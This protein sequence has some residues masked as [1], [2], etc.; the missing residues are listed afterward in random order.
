MIK[1][2]TKTDCGICVLAMYLGIDYDE[3]YGLLLNHQPNDLH[4][5]AVTYYMVRI[6]ADKR[7]GYGY[8]RLKEDFDLSIPAMIK[9]RN[10]YGT[11]NTHFVYWDGK[12]I[13]DPNEGK[14]ITM[15]ELI[16]HQFE[17]YQ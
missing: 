12:K 1:Q 2:R 4:N 7:R 8:L 11:G 14:E 9:V 17:A 13:L 15:S 5:G 3:A 6:C 16:N 10:I